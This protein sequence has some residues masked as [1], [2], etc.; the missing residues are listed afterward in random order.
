MGKQIVNQ[1]KLFTVLIF[2]TVCLAFVVFS[3]FFYHIIIFSKL[4]EVNILPG[5][6]NRRLQL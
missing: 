5:D 3:L 6:L 2:L 1:K 4:K